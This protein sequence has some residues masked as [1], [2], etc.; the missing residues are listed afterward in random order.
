[1]D[2]QAHRNR[3]RRG[4]RTRGSD[5]DR[6]RVGP[7][8]KPGGG[9]VHGDGVLLARGGTAGRGNGEPGRTI[10][11]GVAQCASTGIPHL[12]TLA[13]GVAAWG[14]RGG[15]RR[16]GQRDARYGTDLSL[17]LGN[18]CHIVRDENPVTLRP[19]L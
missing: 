4:G 15:Q 19:I 10:R 6:G 12:E 17:P 18:I 14:G 7:R 16:R 9:V 5:G 13:R 8:G 1:M 3:L 11:D 2:R